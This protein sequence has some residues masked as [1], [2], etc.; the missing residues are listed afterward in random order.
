MALASSVGRIC[1]VAV[2]K[3]M[4]FAGLAISLSRSV[5]QR[6][7]PCRSASAF[8]LSAVRPTSTGSIVTREPSAIGTPPWARIASIERIRCWFTPMR[9]LTPFMITPRVRWDMSAP[10]IVAEL[11]LLSPARGRGRERGLRTS[12]PPLLASPPSG[13]EEL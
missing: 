2:S 11:K 8:T 7:P 1:V 9:P 4:W 13:G 10:Y 12:L 6:S 5:L 3:K